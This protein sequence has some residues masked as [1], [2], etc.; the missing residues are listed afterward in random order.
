[1]LA[2]GLFT[3]AKRWKQSK[4]PLTDEWDKEKINMC[5][6]IYV[7]THT[8]T[9]NWILSKLKKERNSAICD[10][11]DEFGGHYAKWNKPDT[12]GQI[13]HNAISKRN[14]NSQTQRSTE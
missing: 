3:M 8:H 2:A 10:K 5:A 12:E 14:L 4:C 11:M 1:M 6:Y 13:L 7:V 9:Y